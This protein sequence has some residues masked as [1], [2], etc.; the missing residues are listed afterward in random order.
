MHTLLS[1]TVD[2]GRTVSVL[3]RCSS[4]HLKGAGQIRFGVTE[5]DQTQD[6]HTDEEPA[7]EA[8]EVQQ[9]VDVPNKHLDHGHGILHSHTE[10]LLLVLMSEPLPPPTQIYL[11]LLLVIK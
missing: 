4:P 3:W 1:L 10:D 6:H 7:Q 5:I 11:Q 9:T 2:P 8:H